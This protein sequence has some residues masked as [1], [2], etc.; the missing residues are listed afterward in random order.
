M[1]L[2]EFGSSWKGIKTGGPNYTCGRMAI[3]CP[4]GIIV[5]D[6]AGGLTSSA[7]RLDDFTTDPTKTFVNCSQSILTLIGDLVDQERQWYPSD[8]RR[9]GFYGRSNNRATIDNRAIAPPPP[10]SN[11]PVVEIVANPTSGVAPMEVS[12]EARN[13]GQVDATEFYWNLGD[14]TESDQESFTHQYDESG[15]FNVT[16]GENRRTER[17]RIR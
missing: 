7:G 8:D 2:I 10:P 3:Y 15:I 16:F 9:Y 1:R 5:S 14:S 17:H 13:V 4:V 11:N 6:T 12:F